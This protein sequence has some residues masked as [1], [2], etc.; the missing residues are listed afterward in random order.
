L[1]STCCSTRPPT[2]RSPPSVAAGPP[3]G[4]DD[5]ERDARIAVRKEFLSISEPSR[6]RRRHPPSLADP[7]E[8]LS[9]ALAAAPSWQQRASRR[10]RADFERRWIENTKRKEAEAKPRPPRRPRCTAA[11]AAD[12][13]C[14]RQ[15]GSGG[16]SD[17]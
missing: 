5:N 10:A 7:N 9:A 4:F 12:R 11:T 14:R 16:G 8:P 2:R 13:G 15:A 17:H 6:K 3:A 1:A